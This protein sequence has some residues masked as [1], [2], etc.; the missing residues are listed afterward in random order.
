MGKKILKKGCIVWLVFFGAVLCS[1]AFAQ[2]KKVL[3]DKA[4]SVNGSIITRNQLERELTQV[5]QK[6]ASQGKQLTD[7]EVAE[8]KKDLLESLINR[9]L[10][11]QES[12]RQEISAKESEVTEQ[13]D[14]LKKRFPGEVEFNLAL[15]QMNISEVEIKKQIR[16][17]LELKAFIDKN[18]SQKIS[19]SEPELR[20]YYDSHPDF[21]KQPEKVRA[22]HILIKVDS[23]ADSLQKAEARQQLE[24]IQQRLD[25]GEDFGVLAKAFSQ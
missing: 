20:A 5:Q 21:F 25:A 1:A 24:K 16:Q 18:Y 4:A 17:E 22:S 8:I 23:Q 13:Y 11:H 15:K 10:I 14:G 6:L 19:V 7:S 3:E 2:E 12:R 9:E